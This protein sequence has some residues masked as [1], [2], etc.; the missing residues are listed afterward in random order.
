MS[1]MYT[2]DEETANLHVLVKLAC[3]PDPHTRYTDRFLGTAGAG[4]V[5]GVREGLLHAHTC[6]DSIV[7]TKDGG[8]V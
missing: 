8:G 7:S 5:H 6:G 3:S 4:A 2:S 1:A